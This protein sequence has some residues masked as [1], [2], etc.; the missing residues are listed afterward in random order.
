MNSVY[1][2]SPCMCGATDCPRCF[3]DAGD[4]ADDA[5]ELESF[6]LPKPH[7]NAERLEWLAARVT[8]LEHKDAQGLDCQRQEVGG[9]WPHTDNDVSGHHA[10]CLGLSLIQYVDRMIDKENA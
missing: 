6:A 3:P 1:L 4:V 5:D 10:D 2:P 9:W 7:T 8:Y